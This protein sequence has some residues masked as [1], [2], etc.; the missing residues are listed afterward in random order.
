MKRSCKNWMLFLIVAIV[1]PCQQAFGDANGKK[2][3]ILILATGGTIAGAAATGTQSAYTS[4]A[5]TIDAMVNAVPGIKDLAN[6]KGEQVANVG[7][8]DMS[9][10]I[11]LKVAKRINE[12]L[13]T[14]DV[15]GIVVTHG[16]DTMEETAYFLNLVVKSDK[17]VVLVGSM[18]PSTAVSADGPLNLFNAVG[19][20]SDPAS[21][22][23]GVLV[24]MNDWIHGAHSLTK[25]ST[26]AVQTFM[27][28]LRGLVGVT[29]YGKDDFY[30]KPQWKNTTASEFD[31]S[32]VRELPRVDIVFGCADKSPY[33]IDAS[34]NNGAKGIVI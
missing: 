26:T 17:P 3:N 11:M 33:L 10:D 27:S 28:P 15:D 30:S 9:F 22:G 18:R 19:V 21:A 23:R 1:V 25:T 14:N 12:L 5:V 31:V 7:S 34:V 29:A 13:P 20:A 16:T 24:V 6:I 8:Q 32:N 2:P 4:G